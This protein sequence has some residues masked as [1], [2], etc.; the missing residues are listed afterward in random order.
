MRLEGK[1]VKL[2]EKM[3][4]QFKNIRL[5]IKMVALILAV[6]I[7]LMNPKALDIISKLFGLVK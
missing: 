1:I 2:E 5:E 4:G 7:I 3:E 6:L